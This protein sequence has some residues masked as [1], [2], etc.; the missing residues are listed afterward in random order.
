MLYQEAQDAGVSEA[1]G[2]FSQVQLPPS[3]PEFSLPHAEPG[4]GVVKPIS[5]QLGDKQASLIPTWETRQLGLLGL[6]VTERHP[7]GSSTVRFY[8]LVWPG[9]K[10]PSWPHICPIRTHLHLWD[11]FLC[12]LASP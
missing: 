7:V 11:G 4:A 3:L 10:A 1:R 8:R 9:V 2:E 6:H 12:L 5:A